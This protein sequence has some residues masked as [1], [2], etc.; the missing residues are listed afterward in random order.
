MSELEA[1]LNDERS[2]GD[3]LMLDQGLGAVWFYGKWRV[4]P[5]RSYGS[6]PVF[7]ADAAEQV[8]NGAESDKMSGN[9][10]IGRSS[11]GV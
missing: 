8:T 1:F 3:Y 4:T 10:P 6:N 5:M 7:S 11:E 9:T 2:D